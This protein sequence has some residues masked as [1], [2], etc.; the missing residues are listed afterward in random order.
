MGAAAAGRRAALEFEIGPRETRLLGPAELFREPGPGWEGLTDTA[1]GIEVEHDG[2]PGEVLVQ[3]LMMTPEGLAANL[4]L[5]D[6][7]KLVSNR[8]LSPALRL[9]PEQRSRLALFNLG[10]IPLRVAPEVHYRVGA[11]PGG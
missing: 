10:G 5:A 6:R 1:V 11:G 8:A 7:A 2:A 9:G 4:R 3:G